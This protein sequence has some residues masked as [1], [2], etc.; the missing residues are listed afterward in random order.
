MKKY[1]VALWITL[2]LFPQI[3]PSQRKAISDS[4]RVA[5]TQRV[6]QINERIKAKGYNWK[7]DITSKSYLSKDEMKALCGLRADTA[8]LQKRLQEENDMYQQYKQQQQ[9]GL[10]VTETLPPNWISWMGRIKDQGSCGN[11][12]AH[13]ACGVSIALLHHYYGSN[14]GIDLNELDVSNN[15][16]CGMGCQGT[17]YLDCGLSYINSNKCECEQGINQFPNYDHAFYSVSSYASEHCIYHCNQSL[18]AV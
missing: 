9:N 18:L 1:F 7:A 15:A 16:S 6:Q 12:W 17:Y 5:I 4:A 10:L 13:A 2:V 8:N 11:C 3:S 14:I